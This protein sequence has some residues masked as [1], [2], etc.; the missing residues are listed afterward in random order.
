VAIDGKAPYKNVLTHGFTVDADGRKMSKSLGNVVS[1][2]DI[3]KTLGADT[4]RLWCAS[5]DYSSEMT[6][7]DEILRRA[8]DSYRR[9]N[10]LTRNYLI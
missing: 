3:F 6:I 7:S 8:S 10:Y 4:L 5:T 1:P 9:L 2:Q